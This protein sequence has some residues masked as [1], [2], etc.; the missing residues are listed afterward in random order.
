M[1][2]EQIA[3]FDE[4]AGTLRTALDAIL[5]A[6]DGLRDGIDAARAA[7]SKCNRSVAQLRRTENPELMGTL[8]SVSAVQQRHQ[9]TAAALN[10]LDA[11]LAQF[12]DVAR[13]LRLL[14]PSVVDSLNERVAATSAPA[15][16]VPATET[17]VAQ[18][19]TT[20]TTT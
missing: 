14:H 2:P 18:A 4:N 15:A 6:A 19:P 3:Q 8:N 9:A 5:D 12:E 13:D 11:S 17:P 16:E 7:V 10:T 1:T 20:E